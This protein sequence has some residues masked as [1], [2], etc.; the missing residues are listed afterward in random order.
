[1]SINI[2]RFD[3]R[4]NLVSGAEFM[5][6]QPSVPGAFTVAFCEAIQMI[7]PRHQADFVG[8]G[9]SGHVSQNGRFVSLS[10]SIS[11]WNEVG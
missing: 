3:H 1:M 11:G 6:P 9:V 2:S 10:L 8:I 7:D 4:F 5:L